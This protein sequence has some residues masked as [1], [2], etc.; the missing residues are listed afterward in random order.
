V[1]GSLLY[2]T[3]HSRPDI[4]N[5]VREL[6]KCMDGETPSAFKEMKRLAKFVMDTDNYGLK[7]LPTI[8]RAKNGR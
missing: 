4:A 8:S 7:V 5:A 3:K 2:L 1:V 6:L